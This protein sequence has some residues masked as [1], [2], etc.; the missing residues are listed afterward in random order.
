MPVT[1]PAPAQPNMNGELDALN[2]VMFPALEEALKRRQIQVQRFLQERETDSI[3]IE[4][5]HSKIRKLVYKLA[6]VC[7][8]I[9][10]V[11]KA[12]PVGMGKEVACTTSA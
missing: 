7:K 12:V 11:D 5:A 2:D 8:E 10:Q 9:D 1:F 3:A 6:H 4:N